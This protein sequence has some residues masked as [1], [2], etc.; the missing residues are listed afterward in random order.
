MLK[1]LIFPLKVA[2]RFGKNSSLS[3]RVKINALM[4]TEQKQQSLSEI[5]QKFLNV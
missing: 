1:L 2:P 3:R 4:I 5:F